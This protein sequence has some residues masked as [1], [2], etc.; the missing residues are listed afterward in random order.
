MP[1]AALV[2]I[3]FYV[4]QYQGFS[5]GGTPEIPGLWVEVKPASSVGMVNGPGLW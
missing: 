4:H 3:W 1:A 5:A 2:Y